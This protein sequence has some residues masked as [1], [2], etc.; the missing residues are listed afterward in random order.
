MKVPLIFGGLFYQRPRMQSAIPARLLS[1]RSRRLA[2]S[3]WL[4][5][6][7]GSVWLRSRAIRSTEADQV[8]AEQFSRLVTDDRAVSGSPP[9]VGIPGSA[10]FGAHRSNHSFRGHCLKAARSDLVSMLFVR[11]EVATEILRM[12]LAHRVGLRLG[13]SLPYLSRCV[14]ANGCRAL[15]E[16]VSTFCDAEFVA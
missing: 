4:P 10:S 1:R 13:P 5:A 11:N 6:A 16:A 15:H 12:V 3:G 14:V 9:R 7:Q 8:R 2:V